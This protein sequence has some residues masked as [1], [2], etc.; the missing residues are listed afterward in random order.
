MKPEKRPIISEYVRSVYQV[1]AGKSNGKR[2][3]KILATVIAVL[4]LMQSTARAEEPWRFITLAD[5]HLAELYVQPNR[6]PGGV[7]QNVAGLKMLK[8]NYGG[9]LVMAYTFRRI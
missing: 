2:A 9:E 1:S 3:M 7:E 4:M 6:F 8:E 5:W